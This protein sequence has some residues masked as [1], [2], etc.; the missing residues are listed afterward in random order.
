MDSS[1]YAPGH[2]NYVA[3]GLNV[4]EIFYLKG[5]MEFIGQLGCNNTSKIGMLPSA[6]KDVYIKFADNC[7]HILNNKE[8]LNGLKGSTKMKKG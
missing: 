1:I 2:A 7:I 3:G 6:S 5:K 8:R 4:T